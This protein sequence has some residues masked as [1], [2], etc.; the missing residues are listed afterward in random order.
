MT[1]PVVSVSFSTKL[2]D[3]F[4][5]CAIHCSFW[6]KKVELVLIV[7]RSGVPRLLSMVCHIL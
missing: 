3:C 6:L 2:R 7:D 5:V 1:D 4:Q